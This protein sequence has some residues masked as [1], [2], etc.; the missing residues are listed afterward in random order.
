MMEHRNDSPACTHFSPRF[1]RSNIFLLC[2]ASCLALRLP[3]P[4][5]IPQAALGNP[6]TTLTTPPPRWVRFFLFGAF[7]LRPRCAF[8]LGMVHTMTHTS[9][10]RL[11][12]HDATPRISFSIPFSEDPTVITLTPTASFVGL[13]L[14]FV[15]T[16]CGFGFFFVDGFFEIS[17]QIFGHFNPLFEIHEKRNTTPFLFL[18]PLSTLRSFTTPLCFP[19][20]HGTHYDSHKCASAFI[21]L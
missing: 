18:L 7:L 14:L 12:S 17:Y 21:T 2:F 19:F 20:G 13:I 1:I 6:P 3:I 5:V 10:P 15:T 8:L 16:D 11:L 9:V 4:L